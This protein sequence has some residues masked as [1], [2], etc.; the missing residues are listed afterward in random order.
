MSP[1][2]PYTAH[3]MTPLFLRFVNGDAT[4]LGVARS[5]ASVTQDQVTKDI[6]AELVSSYKDR[7]RELDFSQFRKD[8]KT[9]LLD[10]M[11][12]GP[13]P[14]LRQYL[15]DYMEPSLL[16]VVEKEGFS[17]SGMTKRWVM[18][19]DKDATWIEAVVCYNLS[20]FIATMGYN[21][22]RQC[23]GCTKFYVIGKMK[24]VY[25]SESCKK[26]YAP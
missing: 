5:L 11:D 14:Y 3:T 2:L 19:K 24:Y 15:N 12:N 4:P 8:L 21:K 16:E 25:C 26:R 22:I 23:K 1:K 18:I 17:S 6:V 10:L 7:E 20:V 9:L 13:I